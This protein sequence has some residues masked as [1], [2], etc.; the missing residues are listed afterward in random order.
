VIVANTHIGPWARYPCKPTMPRPSP[1][2]SRMW[3]LLPATLVLV[4]YGLARPS[5]VDDAYI[6]FRY[7]DQLTR[8]NGLVF[9]PR[10]RVEGATNALWTLLLAVP[11]RLG[12][13]IVASAAVLGLLAMIL[14]ALLTVQL[15]RALGLSSRLALTCGAAVALSTQ[16]V[17]AA[18]IGL[19]TALFGALLLAALLAVHHNSATG[20]GS[21][22]LG[23]AATRPEG[24]VLGLT[25]VVLVLALADTPLARRAMMCAAGLVAVATVEGIRVLY[26]GAFLPNSVLAKRD[27]GYGLLSSL[28]WH[29]PDGL[30]YT[31]RSFGL[32]GLVLLIVAA[33]GLRAWGRGVRLGWWWGA[34]PVLLTAVIVTAVMGLS[35]PIISGGDWMP[36]ARLLTPYLPLVVIVVTL[37]ARDALDNAG[38]RS[39][40]A[41]V[42][43]P[44]LLVGLAPRPDT[45]RDGGA[46]P[47]SA[48][49]PFDDVGRALQSMHLGDRV[50][51]SDVL[52]RVSFWAPNVL[53]TDPLGLN[54]PRVAATHER[55]SVFG[56]KN[57]AVTAGRRPA[58]FA[59]NFWPGMD[60]LYRACQAQRQGF[61]AVVSAEL[62]QARVFLLVEQAW[63][64]RLVDGLRPYFGSVTVERYDQARAGWRAQF[65]DGQ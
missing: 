55:G 33:L 34:P 28:R 62:T 54:E 29:G 3:L 46:S 10:E 63:S 58:V 61:V 23:L 14:V 1:A 43:A 25:L 65:P 32:G 53:F 64:S 5:F 41:V 36:Y 48:A 16:I 7:A 26:Y 31:A 52:G 60:G 44:L 15:A 22:V 2:M 21:T 51:A 13:S 19:E 57:V 17:A 39:A 50:V 30:L 38:G 40:F 18:T 6:S 56:K 45:L 42:L 35:L 8:G 24:L 20:V 59:S 11:Q 49:R 37:V 9:N 47:L 27:V 12:L 4:T